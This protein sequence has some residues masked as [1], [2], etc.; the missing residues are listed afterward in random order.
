MDGCS[1]KVEAGEQTADGETDLDSP[2]IGGP[3]ITGSGAQKRGGPE[4]DEAWGLERTSE[5]PQTGIRLG[6]EAH[7]RWAEMSPHR[8]QRS[9]E[10]RRG[11]KRPDQ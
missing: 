11:A 5:L 1:V 8:R 10:R 3:C 7:D 2:M 6:R 9:R 4:E